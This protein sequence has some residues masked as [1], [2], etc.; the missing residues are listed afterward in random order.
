MFNQSQIDAMVEAIVRTVHPLHVVL[1]GSYARGDIRGGS[2]VDL[3]VVEKEP[4]QGLCSRWNEIKTIRNVLRPFK[5]A[6]DILVYSQEEVE[7]LKDSLNHVVGEAFREGKVL[8][9]A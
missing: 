1:F 4:F 5:G 8:Y 9:E 3:L 6:K 7:K 2:D